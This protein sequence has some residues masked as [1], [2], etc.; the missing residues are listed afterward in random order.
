MAVVGPKREMDRGRETRRGSETEGRRNHR[1]QDL[2]QG[3]LLLSRGVSP[4][5]HQLFVSSLWC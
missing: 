3:S 4:C 2:D 1:E 5:P